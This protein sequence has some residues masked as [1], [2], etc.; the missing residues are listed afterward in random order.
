MRYVVV[1]LGREDMACEPTGNNQ[2]VLAW[3]RTAATAQAVALNRMKRGG[4]RVVVL[5]VVEGRVVFP[6][7]PT[8]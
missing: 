5:D 2:R 3:C 6:S 7:T 8:R 1:D 4:V